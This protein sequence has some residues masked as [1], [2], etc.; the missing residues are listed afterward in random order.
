MNETSKQLL[1]RATTSRHD[2]RDGRL[3]T[4]ASR[5]AAKL[6]LIGP[7][8]WVQVGWENDR[9]RKCIER[10]VDI[11]SELLEEL[12]PPGELLFAAAGSESPSPWRM[13]ISV[14]PHEK[15]TGVDGLNIFTLRVAGNQVDAETL[16]D[17]FKAVHGPDN[18]EYALLH[19]EDHFETMSETVYRIPVTNGQAFRG[20]FW[21]NFLGPGHLDEF[22][23]DRLSDLDGYRIEWIDQ[24][25]L[26]IVTAPS[27]E[28]AVANEGEL[29]RLTGR[30]RSA[31]RA[32]SRWNI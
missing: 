26:F 14:C 21:A 7:T 6:D 19:P 18:T 22:E 20:V 10:P 23:E 25:G 5:R 28:K 30:F 17:G 1:W 29:K 3:F 12:Q 15:G 16:L 8:E 31:L 27:P 9:E 2:W 24:R 32:D 4:A 13:M 11:P